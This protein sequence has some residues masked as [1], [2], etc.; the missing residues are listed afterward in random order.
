MIIGLSGYAQSG[1]DTVAGMLIGLHGYDNRAFA[2]G[3]RALAYELDPIVDAFTEDSAIYLSSWVDEKGWEKSK[4]S[5]PEIRRILQRLGVGAR[6]V[7]GENVW[8]DLAM[9]GL[10]PEDKV[11]ITDVRFP[12]EAQ[13]IKDLNGE[14]WRIQ[15]PGVL[16][17]NNH[18]SETSMDDWKFDKVLINNAGLDQLKSQIASNLGVDSVV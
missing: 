8:V 3:V 16:P 15:R 4:V 13:A 6:T 5:E 14:I 2:N 12:N 1:K 17:V 10:Q 11:V 18:P 9:K 7:I